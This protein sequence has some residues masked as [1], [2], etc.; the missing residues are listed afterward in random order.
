MFVPDP[1]YSVADS[2]CPPLSHALFPACSQSL[3]SPTARPRV[4]ELSACCNCLLRLTRASG[5]C[6]ACCWASVRRDSSYASERA[7]LD[8]P[9]LCAADAHHKHTCIRHTARR[10]LC[11]G[12]GASRPAE[13]T[14]VCRNAP[15]S[16][17]HACS[18]RSRLHGSMLMHLRVSHCIM[19]SCA[20]DTTAR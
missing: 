14:L 6:G 19:T 1:R 2:W 8:A 4:A 5:P 18:K 10:S 7:S 17:M 12:W 16:P 15:T 9:G 13:Q 20:P 11:R 3:R